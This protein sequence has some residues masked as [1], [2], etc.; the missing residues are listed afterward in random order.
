[1]PAQAAESTPG[2]APAV[3]AGPAVVQPLAPARYKVQFTASDA[4]KVKLDRLAAEMR[5]QVPD[6]DLATLVEIAVTEKL[7]AIEKRRYARTSRP[8]ILSEGSAKREPSRGTRTSLAAT[9]TKPTSRAVPAAVRRAVRERD[10]D[11]CTFVAAD[12]RRCSERGGL[13]FHHEDPFG[14]GGPHAVE[15]VRLLCRAHNQHLAERDYGAAHMMR[16]RSRASEPRRAY[17]IGRSW[18][19]DTADPAPVAGRVA[20]APARRLR[21]A[22]PAKCYR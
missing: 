8:S 5:H 21:H 6:G 15:N 4:L 2:S 22:G 7:A 9:D 12:G 19:P 13:E 11:Q 17:G 1:V 18:P 10:G 3:V 14:R 20:G 16:F